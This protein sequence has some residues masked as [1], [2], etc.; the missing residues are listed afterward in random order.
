M[1]FEL[2]PAIDLRGGRCVRLR[3]GDYT[4]ET[5]F[6]DDPVG[7]AERWQAGGASRLH[8]VDL[9][10]ARTGVPRDLPTIRSILA[11]LHIP[12]QVGGGVRSTDVV[13]SLLELGVDRVV[14]GTRALRDPAWVEELCDRFG[15]SIVVGIDARDGWVA[16]EGWTE[17][18][19]TPALQLAQRLSELPLAALIYTDIA[20]DG[21]MQGPNVT[22]MT[23]MAQAVSIPVIASGGVT[24]ESDVRELA[25]SP[26]A[27]CIVGRAL[28]E[29][30]LTLAGA[31]RAARDSQADY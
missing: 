17:T 7:M 31:L 20:R 19:N 16:T 24:T 29:G 9:D 12:C 5:V 10:G 18:S 14:I 3:Q 21:M 28:Y 1:T 22:A 26:L 25:Q 15:A 30:T 23:A 4:D 13:Q 8:L 27:G 2:I 11:T 6:S